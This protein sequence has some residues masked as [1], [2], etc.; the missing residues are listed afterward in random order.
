MS[1]RDLIAEGRLLLRRV[2]PSPGMTPD[3]WTAYEWVRDNL[4][5]I[6]DELEAARVAY[7]KLVQ[8]TQQ[9]YAAIAS[10]QQQYRTRIAELES[11]LPYREVWSDETPP[12]GM[13]CGTCGYPVESEPCPDHAPKAEDARITELE[14][15][16]HDLATHGTRFDLTPTM[17]CRDAETLYGGMSEYLRRID[18]TI[19]DR[20]RI[21]L[22]QKAPQ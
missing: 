20:A 21:A 13:V 6:L 1:D 8:E 22:G 17:N 10:K 3:P 16:A 15:F 11:A 7:A 5:A 18:D 2:A 19:R 12:G 14:E 9:H 4:G